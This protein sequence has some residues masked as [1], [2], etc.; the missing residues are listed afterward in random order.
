MIHSQRATIR[1]LRRKMSSRRIHTSGAEL[2]SMSWD[3]TALVMINSGTRSLTFFPFSSPITRSSSYSRT[4]GL[5]IR[6]WPSRDPRCA[7]AGFERQSRPL[8]GCHQ[9][10]QQLQDPMASR[11]EGYLR[12]RRRLQQPVLPNL[13]SFS[14]RRD[15]W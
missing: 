12:L 14:H 7:Q 4:L 2:L 3:T 13:R 9:R 1:D 6:R 11:C 5:C 8:A 10:C 15:E